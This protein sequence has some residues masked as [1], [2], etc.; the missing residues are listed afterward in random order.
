MRGMRTKNNCAGC[1][2]F[3]LLVNTLE[4]LRYLCE[5]DECVVGRSSQSMI[6]E[7]ESKGKESFKQKQFPKWGELK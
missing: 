2:E 1:E 7:I 6:D 3:M 4:G 5:T